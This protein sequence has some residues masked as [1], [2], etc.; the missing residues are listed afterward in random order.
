MSHHLLQLYK[1]ILPFKISRRLDI[2]ARRLLIYTIT[3][4]QRRLSPYKK[5][6]CAYRVLYNSHSCSQSVKEIL[7]NY[8]LPD[9]LPRIQK[10]FRQCGQAVK[11]I[12]DRR[13]HSPRCRHLAT[14]EN[15]LFPTL[16]E[17]IF[18]TR[19]G[20]PGY[21]R[22]LDE[23]EERSRRD[24]RRRNDNAV[25]QP[26]DSWCDCSVCYCADFDVQADGN[27]ECCDGPGNCSDSCTGCDGCDFCACD[28][29]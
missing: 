18:P 14:P 17:G 12:R 3:F 15:I 26:Y 24:R 7:Q 9:A 20:D 28:C 1:R 11:I 6:S 16:N 27:G 22:S 10:Q 5:F 8:P 21:G 23:D 13:I 29:A 25:T 2:I 19:R 4:Y